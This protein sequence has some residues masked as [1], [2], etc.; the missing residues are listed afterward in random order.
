MAFAHW[1]SIRWIGATIG[2]LGLGMM[3]AGLLVE[4]YFHFGSQFLVHLGV[5]FIVATIIGGIIEIGEFKEFFERRLIGILT[6]KELIDLLDEK[7][8][9]KLYGDIVRGIARRT[10][11]NPM[12]DY[13]D[14]I[15][16]VCDPLLAYANLRHRKNQGETIHY[17]ILTEA[18]LQAL[19]V[20]IKHHGKVG[21]TEVKL[22]YMIVSP[23]QFEQDIDEFGWNWWVNEVPGL[24]L[25]KHYHF[26]LTVDGKTI[27]PQTSEPIKRV[28]G[29]VEFDVD[30]KLPFQS[31]A[32]IEAKMTYYEFGIQSVFQ[33]TFGA[34]THNATVHFASREPLE[35]FARMFG[36]TD[37]LPEPSIAGNSVS[38]QYPGWILPD[39]GYYISLAK[40]LSE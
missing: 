10:V 20:D 5:A 26:S 17:A 15:S 13:E 9:L 24:P 12:H 30:E 7:H 28:H 27:F 6:G 36:V 1:K 14:Y 31:S 35:L 18:E 8:L 16:A 25:E 29:I 19:G 21:R 37:D 11:T 4:P 32:W 40:P 38:I 23:K 34:L 39:H 2:V 33:S 3:V 22:R